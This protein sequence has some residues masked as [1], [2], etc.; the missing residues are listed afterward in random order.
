MLPS[1]RYAP[2]HE[3]EL[4]MKVVGLGIGVSVVESERASEVYNPRMPTYADVC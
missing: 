3:L 1:C 4:E 2:Q